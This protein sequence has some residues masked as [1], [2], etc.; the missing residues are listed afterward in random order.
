MASIGDL[1]RIVDALPEALRPVWERMYAVRQAT[2][3]LA[4]PP[5]ME[6]WIARQFG[7][8]GVVRE[9]QIIGVTNRLT[10]EAA[11]FNPLRARRPAG[12]SG[13]DTELAE[14]LRHELV[15]DI[16]AQPLRDTPADVF[17]RI[18]GRYSISASNIAKYDGWHGLV[19]PTH[20]NPLEFER[21]HVRDY[22]DVAL[23]WV[24]AA[25]AA[26]PQ[27]IYPLITWNCLPKSGATIAHSHWQ[28]ALAAGAPYARVEL[29]RRAAAQYA[30]QYGAAYMRDFGALHQALGLAL[31]LAGPVA[32]A[33]H[34][35]PLRNH[36]IV[37]W[38]QPSQAASVALALSP[39]LRIDGAALADALHAIVRGLID[40]CGVRAFNMAIALPPL[41]PPREA[42]PDLPVIARVCD[43]G[44]PLTLRNDW[45]AMELYGTGVITEDPL[46]VAA[47]LA[48]FL[49]L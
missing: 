4:P 42:W 45:G 38:M 20:P 11:L 5:A 19:I 18:E 13:G 37:F 30:A 8:L 47:Q 49:R 9:Q 43:R 33:A 1:A 48:T 25:H 2:G 27:A 17:G 6:A 36:E 28:I 10:L 26:D 39:Y 15:D 44:A 21:E 22:L 32:A 14:W 3:R 35:T 31:P 23:R 16:F 34:L 46:R 29:W 40:R 12:A 7:D 41:A 24:A